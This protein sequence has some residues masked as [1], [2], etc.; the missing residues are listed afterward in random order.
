MPFFANSSGVGHK[1]VGGG[2]TRSAAGAMGVKATR[3][4]A[5]QSSVPTAVP[6]APFIYVRVLPIDT[7]LKTANISWSQNNLNEM[8][9]N[10]IIERLVPDGTWTQFNGNS[11]GSI[12]NFGPVDSGAIATCVYD[13]NV[14]SYPNISYRVAAVNAKGS[15]Q[16]SN[17][18]IANFPTT[19]IQL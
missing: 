14:G 7:S 19:T 9:S 4:Y 8:V 5:V 16:W 17:I 13:D 18:G 15:S 10:Y 11:D 1:A 2:S 6:T 3:L 12:F